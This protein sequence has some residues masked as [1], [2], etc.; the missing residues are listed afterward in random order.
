MRA[1]ESIFVLKPELNDKKVD[2]QVE[3]VRG[4]IEK[5]GGR[6]IIVEK[7]GK[8]KLAYLIKKNRFGIYILVR[9]ESEPALISNL[10]RNYKLNEDIIRYMTV[11]YREIAK[12]ASAAEES[13]G[14][15]NPE[16]VKDI[17]DD[18]SEGVM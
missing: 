6:V 14:Q 9:F 3:K 11:L 8:K 2:E 4:F 15:Q 13:A 17:E 18:I 7:W 1:Y 5:S 16:A 12:K 10:Q